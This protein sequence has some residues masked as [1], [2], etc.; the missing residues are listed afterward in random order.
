MMAQ[1]AVLAQTTPRQLSFKHTLQLFVVWRQRRPG[2]N[3]DWTRLFEMIA[4]NRRDIAP[5]V[6]NRGLSNNGLTCIIHDASA[7]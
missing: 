3:G 4:N 7:S 1:A 5:D 2:G 6:L